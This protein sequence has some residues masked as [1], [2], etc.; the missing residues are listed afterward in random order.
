M[1]PSST[2]NSLQAQTSA[3]LR[4]IKSDMALLY[5]DPKSRGG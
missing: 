3:Q 5:L 4:A 1:K 2:A